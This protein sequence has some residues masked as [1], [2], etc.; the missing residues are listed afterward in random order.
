ML[1]LRFCSSIDESVTE[2]IGTHASPFHLRE[3]YLD[4][5]EKINDAALLKLTKPKSPE[6]I[7]SKQAFNQ[8]LAYIRNTFPAQNNLAER[9]VITRLS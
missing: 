9:K 8:L 7:P 4:G 1:S 6:V 2:I 3:L 5:C